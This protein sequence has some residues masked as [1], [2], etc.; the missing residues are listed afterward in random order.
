MEDN[1]FITNKTKIKI[2]ALPLLEIKKDI[3]GD[4]Y[5]LSLVFLSEKKSKEINKIYRNK[6]NPTNILSFNLSKKEGEILMCP[7]VIKKEIKD[8]G[9]SFSKL[10]GFLFIHGVL[11]LKNFD[12]SSKMEELEEKYDQKYFHQPRRRILPN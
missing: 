6:N 8:F 1:F 3:L 4:S 9:R 5:S 12:H 7:G 11:H 2:P 10:I